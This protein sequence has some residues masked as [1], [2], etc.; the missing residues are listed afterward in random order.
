[1]F[2]SVLSYRITRVLFGLGHLS[3]F[4]G[5]KY[6]P[7][8]VW[9]RVTKHAFKWEHLKIWFRSS[10]VFYKKFH[11]FK[12]FWRKSKIYLQVIWR[13]WCV[14]H[15]GLTWKRLTRSRQG[16]N[17]GKILQCWKNIFMFPS[18]RFWDNFFFNSVSH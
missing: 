10:L 5:L 2:F 16:C 15:V 18:S 13:F 6:I 3:W 12:N 4:Q 17:F 7:P 8:T 9:P 1:M 14:Q 11:E